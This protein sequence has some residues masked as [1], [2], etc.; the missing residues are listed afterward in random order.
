MK[1]S[2]TFLWII[3]F[4]SS[5]VNNNAS[6]LYINGDKLDPID[7]DVELDD[8]IR[9]DLSKVIQKSLSY[10][11]LTNEEKSLLINY[12]HTLDGN[13]K[14]KVLASINNSKKIYSKDS[15]R[16]FFNTNDKNKD[17]LI[18][19]SLERTQRSDLIFN[20]NGVYVD[21]DL[22]NKPVGNF[23]NSYS[24]DQ[25]QYLE[26]IIFQSQTGS[27]D[28][29]L[30]IFGDEYEN[31]V[32]GL[33]KFYP[34]ASYSR[35]NNKMY[36]GLISKSLGIYESK[37]RKSKLQ[38]LDLNSEIKFTPRKKQD[39]KKIYV[40]LKYE[41]AKTLI[42]ILKNYVLEFPVF[43]STDMLYQIG[44]PKKIIDYEGVYFPLSN[45]TIN[46]L[47]L[48]DFKNINVEEIFDTYVLGEL[49][50]QE[51]LYASGISRAKVSSN[52]SIIKYDQYECNEREF[53][54]G[55]VAS[56]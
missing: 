40:I 15:I 37:S 7:I 17:L 41:D 35:V 42:P 5:C 51:K 20:E 19:L 23:C 31:Y 9:T 18:K 2:L 33:K 54:L 44:D 48:K 34:E 47:M 46:N 32:N 12:L 24:N 21:Q 14:K 22:L 4:L 3:L 16:Y 8:S 6:S 13:L 1:R 52:L 45:M 36:D 53:I 39:I 38:G 26:K 50:M 55:K 25:R 49:L 10:K 43:A 27:E 30:V 28:E 11:S 29:V 56:K